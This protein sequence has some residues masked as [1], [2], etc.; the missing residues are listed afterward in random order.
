[1]GDITLDFRPAITPKKI[2]VLRRMAADMEIGQHLSIA[3]ERTDAHQTEQLV[4]IL[5]ENGYD[6]QTKGGHQD[7]FYIHARKNK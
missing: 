5:K 3:L 1:M 7:E 2:Q 6:W 4:G